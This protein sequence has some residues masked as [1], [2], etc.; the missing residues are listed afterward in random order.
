MPARADW[1]GRVEKLVGGGGAALAEAD[2]TVLWS[3][4]GD[5]FLIPASILKIATA[6]MALERLG[7]DYRFQTLFRVNPAGD[8]IISGRGDPLLISEEIDFITARLRAAGLTDVRRIIVDGTF[9]AAGQDIPGRSGSRNPYDA[10]NGALSVNFNTVAVRVGASGRVR[11]AEPQTPLTPLAKAEAKASGR[12]GK[13]RLSLS[14]DPARCLLYAG[15]LFQAFLEAHGVEVAGPVDPF[16]TGDD[17][18][19]KVILDH[20][21][22][23]DLAGV[24][25]KMMTFSNNFIANQ[26]FLTLGAAVHGPPADMDK[27]RRVAAAWLARLGLAGARMVEGSGLSRA[28]RITPRQMLAVLADFAPH[29]HLLKA[30]GRLAAKTGTLRGV[31]TYAGYIDPQSDNPGLFV[32]MLRGKQARPGNRERAGGLLAAGLDSLRKAK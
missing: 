5:H 1:A 18:G 6:A 26:V 29:R 32:V 7:P 28:N 23:F 15:Q 4:G 11:S 17:A 30:E 25:G 2:G 8:L 10:F 22:R 27:S 9:F 20:R 16:R 31:Q 12:K 19:A 24:V 3:R 21:S 14:D 13:L